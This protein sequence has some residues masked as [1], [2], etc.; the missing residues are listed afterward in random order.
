MNYVEEKFWYPSIDYIDTKHSD[1]LDDNPDKYPGEK[2][3]PINLIDVLHE[4]R[5]EPGVYRKAAVL[6]KEISRRHV[7]E[8]GNTTTA[9]LITIDFLNE[10][11][12]EFAPEDQD[13]TAKVGNN[14]GQ[15]KISEIADFLKTGEINEE[16]LPK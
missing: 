11:N 6:F 9:I 12:R 2:I 1:I 4:A 16:R 3:P 5:V 7:Y 8:D 14:H 10:N 13:L 15:F